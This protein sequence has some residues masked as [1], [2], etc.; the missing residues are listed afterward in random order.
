LSFSPE[1][2]R[3]TAYKTREDFSRGSQRLLKRLHFEDFS[4][5]HETAEDFSRS[6]RPGTSPEALGT[7]PGSRRL[8]RGPRDFSAPRGLLQDPRDFSEL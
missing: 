6:E 7:P 2:C 1:A 4:R 8:L 3:W 5:G